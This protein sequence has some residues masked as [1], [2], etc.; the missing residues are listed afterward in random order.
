MKIQ[1]RIVFLMTA[2]IAAVVGGMILA[3]VA[4]E[5]RQLAQQERERVASVMNSI[6]R[7]AGESLSLNDDVMLLSY[8]R[9]QM[10]ESPE[11]EI[12]LVTKSGYTTVL[13]KVK[14]DLLY[15]SLTAVAPERSAQAGES[16]TVQVGFSKTFM[17]EKMR[18]ENAA[19]LAVVLGIA[20]IGLGLGFGGA[21]LISRKLAK[22]VTELSAAADK[23][24]KGD[25]DAAVAV[26]GA[27]EIS[28]LG[29]AF[30]RMA[31]NIRE[32]VRAKEDLL[33]TL[34]HELNNPLA[35]LKAFIALLRDPRRVSTIQ[36]TFQAYETMA[37]AVGQME[38]TLSNALELFRTS[39]N[40]SIDPEIVDICDMAREVISLY[41]PV[42]RSNHIDL[43]LSAPERGLS[44]AADRKLLRRIIIN[45]VSNALKYTP[46][47][48]SITVTAADR[49][50]AVEFSV[51]D[52]GYGISKEDQELLFTKFYRTR[53]ADGKRTKIPGT[54]LGLAITKQA[55]ELHR[56]KIWL[57]SEKG[58]GSTFTISLPKA[59]S[60]ELI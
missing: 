25:L 58:K 53:G 12:C 41:G 32:S 22:P 35:G 28:T 55:V 40:P 44:L 14:S 3:L 50:G 11:I 51:A 43:K 5:Q 48:G 16:V 47:R 2:V 54:G 49:E 37:E 19:L 34:T 7:T 33:S 38:L 56:G 27:D 15:K 13:G 30:N 60:G 10:Q 39:A 45:L 24:G 17:Q 6:T 46:E 52:T 21:L 4:L 57:E 1:T 18:R 36:E 23:L 20:F 42:A 8:L 31:G 26:A 59:V 29:L 9:F